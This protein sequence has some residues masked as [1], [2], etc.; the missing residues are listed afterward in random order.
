MDHNYPLKALLHD[1]KEIGAPEQRGYFPWMCSEQ[2]VSA[3]HSV[4]YSHN[5]PPASFKFSTNV[6][7]LVA[8]L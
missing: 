3:D 6:F 8:I 1:L 4:L 2:N 5:S 7:A